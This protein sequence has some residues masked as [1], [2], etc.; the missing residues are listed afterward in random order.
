MHQRASAPDMMPPPACC[1]GVFDSGVGGL[2]VL[3]ALRRR[4]PHTRLLYAADSA[5]APYGERD[6]SY[7]IDRSRRL[8]QFLLSQG[9]QAIVVACNTATALAIAELRRQWPLIPFVG[10]EPAIKPALAASAG[11]PV[12]VLATPATLSSAKF[13][14]LVLSLN[15]QGDLLLQPCPGLAEAIETLGP[16]APGTRGLIARFCAPLREAGCSTVVLGCTHYPLVAEAIRGALGAAGAGACLLDPADA[17]AAQTGRI[18]ASLQT[19][20]ARRG[21]QQAPELIAWTN[22]QPAALRRV[23][24]ACGLDGMPVRTLPAML[25]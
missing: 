25:E 9:A 22:G 13:Q 5:Y 10:I 14:A 19:P 3:T 6:A 16:D 21:A 1:V 8:A 17:V 7:V 20:A 2:T 18:V 4:L 24:A 11:R 15:P 23:A 12:G